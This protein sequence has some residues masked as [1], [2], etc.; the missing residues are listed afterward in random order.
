TPDGI[1][2][3]DVTETYKN[4]YVPVNMT[5]V[6]VGNFDRDALVSQIKSNFGRLARKASNGSKLVKP[7][8]TKG[9][10][11]VTG[12]FV[13]LLGSDTQVGFAY[14][15]EGSDSPDYYAL[16]VLGKY[17]NRILYKRVRVDTALSY[18]PGASYVAL[19]DYGIF[20]AVADVNLDK[21]ELAK[22]L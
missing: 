1:S 3:A 9:T 13:P 5:L 11:E 7:P 21:V 6:V 10:R 17:L 19:K 12:T 4:Y 22:A 20:V 16:S 2:E 18:G 14:R 8:Y 15:T